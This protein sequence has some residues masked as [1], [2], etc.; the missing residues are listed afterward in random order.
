MIITATNSFITT[1][2]ANK[3][4]IPN[5]IATEPEVIDGHFTGEVSGCPSYQEGKVT[6]LQD[7]LKD[8]QH[9]LD[10]SYFYSDSHNDLPLLELV[11]YPF[12]VDPDP[13]LKVIAQER[14]WPIIS[15][16]Q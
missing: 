1:P 11:E 14:R 8:T 12:A 13:E 16:R 4:G 5:L 7:W 9:S 10:G 6:R 3:L 15:L 2:I